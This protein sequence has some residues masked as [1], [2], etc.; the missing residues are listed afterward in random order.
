MARIT[1]TRKPQALPETPL[2]SLLLEHLSALA[3]KNYSAHTVRNHRIYIG[4][5][6]E[7]C[8]ERGLIDP[9]EVTRPVLERYQRHLFHYRKKDGEPVDLLAVCLAE[10]LEPSNQVFGCLTF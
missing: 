4:F 5:F 10:L 6:L 1:K 3:V 8:K 9:V 2:E 7:W